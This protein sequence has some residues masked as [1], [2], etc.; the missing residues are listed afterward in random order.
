MSDTTTEYIRQDIDIKLPETSRYFLSDIFESDGIKF[1]ETWNVIIVPVS[2]DDE[3]HTITP[4]EEGRWDLLSHKKYETVLYWWILCL[5]NDVKNPL[6]IIPAGNIVRLPDKR[7]VYQ[8]T[9]DAKTK[10]LGAR[11]LK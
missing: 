2:S 11:K 9:V 7:T 1:F 5:A 3:F 10:I 8:V 6:E 4:G